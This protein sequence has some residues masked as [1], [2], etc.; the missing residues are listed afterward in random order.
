MRQCHPSAVG[1]ELPSGS[2]TF[3][4]T[5]IEGSTPLLKRLGDRYEALLDR[6]NQVLREA[7]ADHGGAEFKA[8]G[9]ALLVA[10]GSAGAAF[11]AAVEGQR[12]LRSES[13]PP[14]APIRVRMGLHTGIA[15]PR[16]GDYI[17]LALHQAAR[18][19]GA[20]NGGQVLASA[21][22]VA[23]ADGTEL[24]AR[25]LGAY[26]LRDFDGPADLF[27]ITAAGDVADR[28]PVLRAV[29]AEGHNLS[30][31]RDTF[32][33]RDEDI[34]ELSAVVEPGRLVTLLG[35]GGIG[36]TRLTIEFALGAAP[37][38]DDGVWMV[39]LTALPASQPIDLAVAEALGVVVPAD[40]DA[41]DSV[42][43]HL[44]GRRVL[45]ILDN[46]EHVLAGAR[47]VARRVLADCPDTAL[48]TTSRERLGVR[49]E[50]TVAV[51]PLPLT[52]ECV[53]LFLDRARARDSAFHLDDA[54]RAVMLDIC[55]RLD[56]MPLGIELAA[57]RANV[58]SPAEILEGL[59]RRLASL[60]RRDDAV[61]ERQRT[62]RGL[63][64]WSYD[65]LGAAEQAVFRRLSVFVGSFDMAAAGAAAGHGEIDQDEVAE[66]V[67]SLVDRSLV[68]V[69]RREGS[70]R[71]RLLETIGAVASEY[72]AEAGDDRTTRMALGEHYF[73]DFPLADCGSPDRRSRLALE[74]MTLANL[75]AALVDDGQAELAHTLA[76][77]AVEPDLDRTAPSI[78]LRLLV[79]L[80]DEAREPSRGSARIHALAARLLA[81]GG[82]RLAAERH[83]AAARR[84]MEQFGDSDRHGPVVL[85]GA[86]TM[87][88]LRESSEAS[89]R[90]AV[91]ALD[92]DLG[93]PL[94]PSVRAGVLVDRALVGQALGDGATRAH[95]AEAVALAEVAGDQVV[96]TYALNN[97]AE[98][99]LRD[100]DV[101]AA[102]EH[103]GEALRLSAEL[104]IPLITGFSLVLAARMAQPAGRD[105]TAVRLHAAADA[106]FEGQDFDL[107]PDDRALSDAMLESARATLGDGGFAAEVATGRAL[108]LP[109]LL[110]AAEEVFD[111]ARHR[112]GGR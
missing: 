112:I 80:V 41:R 43:E 16:N 20:A 38:W 11:E 4:L 26:R 76:R 60:G 108:D 99:E 68:T 25:R 103:Q 24:V 89:M 69:E 86:L 9:D 29:P 97:L 50:H 82:D 58:L 15:F 55:R 65:L 47:D 59:G 66:V 40:T 63:I 78:P 61:T 71:Y 106:L 85:S 23:A 34:A 54:D 93:R 87:L 53:D 36:K 57:A 30:P 81:G 92:H 110:V 1:V 102:A 35:P 77:L 31:L 64:A 45:L 84:L 42:V 46:C 44:R 12:R 75:V 2:V 98:E 17:A 27:E 100:G 37:A 3:L 10:F 107:L 62:L 33:G 6:H 52:D 28:F 74:R 105:A 51:E 88:S 22:A 19:V 39:D 95:L 90:A 104:D 56:G 8:E 79:P 13:W 67:W 111:E 109:H 32:I 101:P 91:G 7:W 18:V 5:D 49:G 70:T 83:L 21:D 14:D 96:R 48:L 73:T 94:P 72:S